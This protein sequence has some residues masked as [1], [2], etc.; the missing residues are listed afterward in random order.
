MKHIVVILLLAGSLVGCATESSSP[1]LVKREQSQPKNCDP[2]TDDQELV[3]GISQEMASSGKLHA[4][5]ANLERLPAHLP[6]A[7]L[8]KAQLLRV[9]GR[10]EAEQ[11]YTDLVKTCLVADA[12]HGLGQMQVARKN[13]PEALDHLRK[14][15]SLSPANDA[16]RN[17]LG[18]AYLNMQRLPEAHFELMTA[19]EL[20]ESDTRA[21]QN[22]LTLLIYQDK[23]NHARDLVT[24]KKLTTAQFRDAEKRASQ[25]KQEHA[26]LADAQPKR[27]Q[28]DQV[29]TPA[30]APQVQ[31][32]P[33]QHNTAR[34]TPAA[35]QPVS[36][37]APVAAQ[38]QATAPRPAA[39]VQRTAPMPQKPAV[40]RPA[41]TP[42]QPQVAAPSPVSEAPKAAVQRPATVRRPVT[43]VQ[44]V[45][46]PAPVAAQPRVAAPRPTPVAVQPQ[47]VAPGPAPVQRPAPVA[48]QPQTVAPRPVPAPRPAAAAPVQRQV[49]APRPISAPP[50]ATMQRSA[51]QNISAPRPIPV[52]AQPATNS[53]AGGAIQ[54]IKRAPSTGPRPI[55]AITGY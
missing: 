28:R 11:L 53:A 2:L 18:V 42:V 45:Q 34:T 16:M 15:T 48:A 32:T 9:L 36:R 43:A 12:H 21:A 49:A 47:A 24:R 33:Q 52:S 27:N 6:E 17:D 20:N 1:W 31:T 46:R 55:E 37:P 5:L 10:S 38:R 41:A 22:M 8:R 4:A 19:M 14:A 51:Q 54:G 13:Y 23:W 26:E 25:L 50:Q 35:Q 40:Q 39:P 44:K 29:K 3:L 7:R 30:V